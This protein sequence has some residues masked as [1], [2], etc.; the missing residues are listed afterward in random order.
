MGVSIELRK[1]AAN[2]PEYN[3]LRNIA[4][5]DYLSELSG[6][7]AQHHGRMSRTRYHEFLEA[8]EA[9][10]VGNMSH[11]GVVPGSAARSLG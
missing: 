9:G 4:S 8:E 10:Y 11:I 7:P 1:D 3:S 5:I 6:G 2:M